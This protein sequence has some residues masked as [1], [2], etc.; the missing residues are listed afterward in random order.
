MI[1]IGETSSRFRS[2]FYDNVC[3]LT[4]TLFYTGNTPQ[5]MAFEQAQEIQN[6]SGWDNKREEPAHGL[7]VRKKSGARVDRAPVVFPTLAF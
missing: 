7:V 5:D 3:V 6:L 2:I 4:A 1:L